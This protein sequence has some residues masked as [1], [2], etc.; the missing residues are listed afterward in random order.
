MQQSPA[1]TIGTQDL[2]PS[3]SGQQCWGEVVV[4]WSGPACPFLL[5]TAVLVGKDKELGSPI[6]VISGMGDFLYMWSVT[7]SFFNFILFKLCSALFVFV[8]L[9]AS[10]GI[11]LKCTKFWDSSI[12]FAPS[13]PF[14]FMHSSLP[15]K[16]IHSPVLNCLQASLWKN[17]KFIWV[18]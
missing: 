8:Y 11:S 12:V 16:H 10:I 3:L 17:M 14:A 1:V 4:W 5:Y 9:L 2:H 15:P 6:L 18:H 13:W 7:A